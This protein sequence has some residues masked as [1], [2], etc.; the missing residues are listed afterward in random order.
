M[1]DAL[2]P[3]VSCLLWPVPAF[4]WHLQWTNADYALSNHLA[5]LSIHILTFLSTS[6]EVA[7][8]H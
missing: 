8:I 4:L 2:P 7:E 3:F 6:S 1:F 5:V